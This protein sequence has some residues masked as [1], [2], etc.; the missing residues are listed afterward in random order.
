MVDTCLPN[1][2]MLQPVLPVSGQTCVDF[3]SESRCLDM[4]SDHQI[5]SARHIEVLELE[6]YIC[7]DSGG[8][9]VP[10]KVDQSNGSRSA[11]RKHPGA[12]RT[13]PRSCTSVV[14][15]YRVVFVVPSSS[16]IFPMPCS[17]SASIFHALHVY[18]VFHARA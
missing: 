2:A 1:R 4:A 15:L 8:L 6:N 13:F 17:S 16:S 11:R 9:V 10:P 3:E 18:R 12:L 14:G 7:D 5:Y